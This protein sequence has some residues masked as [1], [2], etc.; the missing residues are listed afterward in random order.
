MDYEVFLMSRIREEWG[1]SQDPR[2]SV[3]LGVANTARVITTAALIMIAVFFSFVTIKNPTIQVLG[4][5]MAIAVLL[6]S[7]I[8][9][10]VLVPAVMELLGKSAWW[11]PKWLEWLPKLNIEG[12][13]ELLEA[14][15]NMKPTADA[16]TA[17]DA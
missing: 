7:T 10:M 13:P 3:V 4:F 2:A 1:K 17:V 15:R 11:F 16:S 8:V 12:S 14:E 6:D 5:G 9:R